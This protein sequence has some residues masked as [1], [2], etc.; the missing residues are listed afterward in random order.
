MRIEREVVELRNTEKKNTLDVVNC[1]HVF[2]TIVEAVGMDV[3]ERFVKS[4][5]GKGQRVLEGVWRLFEFLPTA[6]SLNL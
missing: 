1:L 4:D 3:G 2:Q 6:R 5:G